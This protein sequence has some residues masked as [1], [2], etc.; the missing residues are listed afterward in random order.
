MRKSLEGNMLKKNAQIL[1]AMKRLFLFASFL[2]LLVSCSKDEVNDANDVVPDLKGFSPA[3]QQRRIGSNLFRN[4]VLP[5][6][7]VMS[8]FDFICN[9]TF[10]HYFFVGI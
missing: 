3:P 7:R 2:F 8:I 5:T 10:T 1:S 9:S 6:F 4:K